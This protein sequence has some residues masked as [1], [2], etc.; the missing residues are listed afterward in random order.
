MYI[1]YFADQYEILAKFPKEVRWNTLDAIMQYAFMGIEPKLDDDPIAYALFEWSRFS[2]DKSV[3]LAKA[4]IENW[5][6]WWAPKWNQNA[7][8][9][10]QNMLKQPEDNPKQPRTKNYEQWTKNDE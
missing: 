7:V 3:K 1:Q 5:K 2:V 4:A 9:S 8:K 6:K 10:F